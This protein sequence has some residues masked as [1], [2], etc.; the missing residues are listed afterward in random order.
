MTGPVDPV[1]AFERRQTRRR[2]EDA[3]R[4]AGADGGANVP[5]IIEGAHAED[6]A[7][8]PAAEGYS[9]FTAQVYGQT[10]QKRGLRGGQ[11]VFDAARAAYLETE[12]SGPDDRRPPK[13]LIRKTEI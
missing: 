6:I 7:D 11:P 13:G 10:G 2:T 4:P 9:T 8:P 12:Y 5:A 3:G 1:R